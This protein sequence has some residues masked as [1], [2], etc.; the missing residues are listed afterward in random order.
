MRYINNLHYLYLAVDLMVQPEVD[1]LTGASCDG[2]PPTAPAPLLPECC[3]RFAFGLELCEALRLPIWVVWIAC[4]L[5]RASALRAHSASALA[6]FYSCSTLRCSAATRLSS[7]SFMLRSL[8]CSL[9]FLASAF[10]SCNRFSSSSLTL[11]HTRASR[12]A[13]GNQKTALP[14]Y[15]SCCCRSRTRPFFLCFFLVVTALHKPWFSM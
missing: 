5:F 11:S 4:L 7:F 1:L 10:W 3:T 8:F 2:S 9:S 15:S 12:M 13:Q 14:Q 6:F